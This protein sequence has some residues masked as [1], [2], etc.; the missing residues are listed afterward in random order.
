M[1]PLL[2]L[3]FELLFSEKAKEEAQEEEDDAPGGARR[4]GNGY[5]VGVLCGGDVDVLSGD[6]G[7][8]L[9]ALT[10][11]CCAEVMVVIHRFASKER[12]AQSQT[13]E[14][15]EADGG[16]RGRRRRR[17]QRVRREGRGPMNDD[18]RDDRE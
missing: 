5:V 1:S 12:S 14:I 6:D 18:A 16:K 3:I 17:W 7:D 8:A 10:I 13:K 2:L 11:M 4:S 15:N 9:Y